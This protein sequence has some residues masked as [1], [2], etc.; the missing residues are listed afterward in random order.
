MQFQHFFNDAKYVTAE[1]DYRF[2]YVRKSFF[3]KEKVQKATLTVSVLGFGK[4]YVNGRKINEDLYL[5][6]Y[7][8]YNRQKKEDVPEFFHADEFFNDDIRYSI[9]VSSFDVSAEIREGKNAV[10][11]L[12]SGGWYRS[13]RDM[14]NSYRNYGDTRVC[15]CIE[16]QTVTGAKYTVNSDEACKWQESFLIKGGVF[17][18]EQDEN[19]EIAEFALPDYDDSAWKPVAIG[20]TPQAEYRALDCPSNKIMRTVTA[21]LVKVTGNTKIYD[22]GENLT[23]YPVILSSGIK[24]D[25]ITCRY[26]EEITADD[27]L[28]EKH[29]YGQKSVFRTDGRTEHYLRFTW[30]GFRYFEL[31]SEKGDELRCERVAVVHADVK[32]TS[33]FSCDSEITNW[34]HDAYVRTQLSN[35]Q[36]GVP[37]DCPHIERKGYT[38]DGQLLCETAMQM[39]DA[40]RLYRKWIQDISDCQD[41]TTGF[42]HYTAPVFIGCSGGPGGWSVAIVTVPYQ[43]YKAYGDAEIL[44]SYYPQM[45]AYVNFIQNNLQQGL[46]TLKN[47]SNTRCLGDWNSL[48]F[49][50]LP[51]R[52]ANSCMYVEALQKLQEIAAVIG[53]DGDIPALKAK[54]EQVKTAIVKAFYD[55]ETGDFC[56]NEQASNAFALKIGLGDQRTLDNLVKRYRETKTY[57]TGIFGTKILTEML[58]KNGEAD[59]AYGLWASDVDSSFEQWKK[60]GAM[61]LREAWKYARSYNHPMFGALVGY[62]YQYILGIRQTENSAGYTELVVNPLNFSKIGKAEGSIETEKG[63]IGVAFNTEKDGK[64]FIVR[65]PAGVKARFIYEGIEKQI[66][67]G[68]NEIFCRV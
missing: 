22:A 53:A 59:V 6:T 42:V 13:E 26:S 14:Y 24:D 8:Q 4:V 3:V 54:E 49:E 28:D 46:V 39:F 40:K 51:S 62:F 23:G 61:T 16:I 35:Y 66:E 33:A 64:R 63:E 38:G 67:T 29:I 45:Q 27:K 34:L 47:R 15:F 25:T 60:D 57:D 19:K 50:L 41:R 55:P 11:V 43:Y 2:P 31:T 32:Q 68:E 37:T 21:K 20:E 36:C 12:V 56:W 58:L 10:G 7:S 48:C 18:E 5:T 44:K 17:E 52:Y 65:I 1:N 9:Y 30:H